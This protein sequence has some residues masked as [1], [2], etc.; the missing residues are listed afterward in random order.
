MFTPAMTASSTSAPAVIILK[1]LATQVSPSSSLDLLPLAEEITTGFA[2]R[3][4]RMRGASPTAARSS[5][6]MG[7]SRPTMA[8]NLRRLSLFF[9][10]LLLL[11]GWI[12]VRDAARLRDICRHGAFVAVAVD[13]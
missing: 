1:A 2:R 13:R 7:T 11:Q 6:A 4:V 10:G 9:I 3:F 5:G 12:G 8:T